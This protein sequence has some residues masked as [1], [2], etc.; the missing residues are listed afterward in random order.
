MRYHV[1]YSQEVERTNHIAG[2]ELS[3][4]AMLQF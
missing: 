3:Y 1:H 2:E 4:G